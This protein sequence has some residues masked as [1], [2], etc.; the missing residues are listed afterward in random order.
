MTDLEINLILTQIMLIYFLQHQTIKLITITLIILTK[1]INQILIKM[2]I[3]I[4][5]ISKFRHKTKKTL[6]LQLSP[7]Y[8]K[9]VAVLISSSAISGDWEALLLKQKEASV[10]G[11]VHK[12]ERELVAWWSKAE[13]LHIKR[14]NSRASKLSA[15]IANIMDIIDLLGRDST[16]ERM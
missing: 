5:I 12:T 3:T 8:L 16:F 13:P 11:H 2:Q 1:T 10:E 7:S 14:W 4:Q 9:V 6:T 15:G